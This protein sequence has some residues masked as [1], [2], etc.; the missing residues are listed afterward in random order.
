MFTYGTVPAPPSAVV[1]IRDATSVTELLSLAGVRLW[2]KRDWCAEALPSMAMFRAAGMLSD[3][4]VVGGA[5]S[6]ADPADA[7]CCRFLGLAVLGNSVA[8]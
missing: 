4:L 2:E 6:V 8:L 3:P 5:V 1:K 7:G